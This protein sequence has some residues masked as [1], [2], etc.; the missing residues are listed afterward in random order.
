MLGNGSQ[1]YFE[2]PGTD[3]NMAACRLP[4]RRHETP[5]VVS[6]ALAFLTGVISTAGNVA[7]VATLIV[8]SAR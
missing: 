7:F 1:T 8:S 2:M 4:H 3:G 6:A 5:L